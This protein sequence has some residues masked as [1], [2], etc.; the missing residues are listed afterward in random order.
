MQKIL[1]EFSCYPV[2]R[3]EVVTGLRARQRKKFAIQFL[4]GKKMFSL[5]QIVQ[6]ALGQPTLQFNKYWR[7][8]LW[9]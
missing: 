9:E 7:L 3:T 2:P 1:Y 6:P 8:Y 4:S 5:R